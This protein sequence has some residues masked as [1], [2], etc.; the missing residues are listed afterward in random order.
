MTGGAHPPMWRNQA[1]HRL[2]KPISGR[3]FAQ[4]FDRDMRDDLSKG[5]GQ[6]QNAAW[7]MTCH[8]CL[9][10]GASQAC[11]KHMHLEEGTRGNAMVWT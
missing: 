4:A 2:T 9:M 10:S 6:T 3:V 7:M 11:H 1:R 8:Q 5:G